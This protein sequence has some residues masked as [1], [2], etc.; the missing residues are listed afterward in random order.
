MEQ[1]HYILPFIQDE[2]VFLLEFKGQLI[3]FLF[4]LPDHTQKPEVRNRFII[5]TLAT[6]PEYG[7]QGIA[8]C[9]TALCIAQAQRLGF[10]QAIHA[11]MF[12]SNRSRS[13][14]QHYQQTL[15]RRYSLFSKPL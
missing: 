12:E 1:Y 3:A 9:L 5:K 10:T 15:L 4:S 14:S 8:S 13:I 11:L 6:D 2:L 7:G